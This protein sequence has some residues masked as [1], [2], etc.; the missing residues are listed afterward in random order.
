MREEER[1]T[2]REA[3]CQATGSNLLITSEYARTACGRA[4]DDAGDYR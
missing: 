4:K 2:H 3:E 1:E